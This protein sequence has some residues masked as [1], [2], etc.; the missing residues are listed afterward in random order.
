MLED[1]GR[2]DLAS[3][4]RTAEEIEMKVVKAKPEEVA[5]HD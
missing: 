5:R 4:G 3:Q 1:S 2:R